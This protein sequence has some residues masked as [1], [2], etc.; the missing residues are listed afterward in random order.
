MRLKL[1]ELSEHDGDWIAAGKR[2]AARPPRRSR[3]RSKDQDLSAQRNA[4]P[5]TSSHG[6]HVA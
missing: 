3:Q 5:S 1:P 2:A 4:A 6:G